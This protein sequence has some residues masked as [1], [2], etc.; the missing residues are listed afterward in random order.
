VSATVSYVEQEPIKVG[1]YRGEPLFMYGFYRVDLGDFVLL[2]PS[3]SPFPL[4][5]DE[6]FRA[7]L[8]AEAERTR[9]AA[10]TRA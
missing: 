5:D 2:S 3:S 8:V 6:E 7:L 4:H 10:L 9:E 1:E